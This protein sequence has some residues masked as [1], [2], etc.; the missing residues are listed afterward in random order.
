ME[1]EREPLGLGEH[2][3]SQG[4][5]PALQQAQLLGTHGAVGI[6]GRERLLGEDVETGEEAEAEP[7][8]DPATA[9]RY[10]YADPI[11]R[12]EGRSKKD[13]LSVRDTRK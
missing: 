12:E 5:D 3:R 8:P 11:L 7:D 4:L 6:V 13:E 9:M 1:V 2:H 10:V